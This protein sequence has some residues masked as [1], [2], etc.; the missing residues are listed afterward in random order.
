MHYES[1]MKQ[2]KNLTASEVRS[3]VGEETAVLR[4]ELNE[5]LDKFNGQF[6]E[7]RSEVMK[8]VDKIIGLFGNHA[9]DHE[10]LKGRHQ[11][12]LQLD[13]RIEKLEKVVFKTS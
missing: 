3:I 7:F 2:I 5:R 12:I 9:Q 8:S 1:W 4:N 13:D 11:Q 10:I 6:T